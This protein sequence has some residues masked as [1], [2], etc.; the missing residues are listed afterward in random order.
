MPLWFF[1]TKTSCVK[2]GCTTW[3]KNY[4]NTRIYIYSKTKICLISTFLFCAE[5]NCSPKYEDVD[6]L[7]NG[8]FDGGYK[9]QWDDKVIMS[10]KWHVRGRVWPIFNYWAQIRVTENFSNPTDIRTQYLCSTLLDICYN[11]LFRYNTQGVMSTSQWALR[12][13]IRRYLLK[14]PP[15]PPRHAKRR[16]MTGL[17]LSYSGSAG[18][19]TLLFS[20]GLSC[21]VSCERTRC[22]PPMLM[23]IHCSLFN[24]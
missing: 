5:F 1:F 12:V 15:P 14:P 19:R 17:F 21:L 23:F 20:L 9:V 13:L 2:A 11:K 3:K 7:S 6:L 8:F 18:R 24:I 4:Q 16:V 10:G 22:I